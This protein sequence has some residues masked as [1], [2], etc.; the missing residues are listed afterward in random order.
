VE[1]RELTEDM[2]ARVG[3]AHVIT[4]HVGDPSKVTQIQHLQGSQHREG[5]Y[6]RICDIPAIVETQIF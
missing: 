4:V 6:G 1:S 2:N 5:L 3:N